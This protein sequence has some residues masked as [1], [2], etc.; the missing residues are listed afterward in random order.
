METELIVIKK[1]YQ[2]SRIEPDF[3]NLLNKEG[4]I[5]IISID[6]EQ[7]IHESYLTNL[8]KFARLYYDLSINVEGIDV[9]N[10]LLQRMEQ[11]EK[12]LNSIR[13]HLNSRDTI[14]DDIDF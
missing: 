11:M 7:Y 1:I 2:N 13:K 12:E 4:L 6:G 14:W 10:N 5:D 3:L 9:I 8:E